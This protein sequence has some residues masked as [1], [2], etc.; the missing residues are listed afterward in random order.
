MHFDLPTLLAARSLLTAI[1]GALL[2]FVCLRSTDARS[3]LWWGWPSLSV[4]VGPGISAP[5][6]DLSDSAPRI[7]VATCLNI[8]ASMFWAAAHRSNRPTV[9]PVLFLAGPLLWLGSL[10]I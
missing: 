9:P 4:S 1:S 5:L 10:A 2:I 6:Q 8:A 7:A 3:A